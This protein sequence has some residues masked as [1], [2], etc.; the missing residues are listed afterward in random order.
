MTDAPRDP[1]TLAE[2]RAGDTV[3][4]F[5]RMNNPWA[6][7]FVEKITPKFIV[8]ERGRKYRIDT[9][10]IEGSAAW[11]RDRIIVGP[12]R[13]AIL[14]ARQACEQRRLLDSALSAFGVEHDPAGLAALRDAC[15]ARLKELG[16]D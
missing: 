15:E 6:S 7:R 1:Q 4:V 11:G 8:L 5:D 12:A 3:T 13:D 14:A 16:D 9:G 2:V 10:F